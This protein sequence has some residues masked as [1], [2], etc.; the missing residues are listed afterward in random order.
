MV[1][2]ESKKRP[3][4]EFT[5]EENEQIS[6]ASTGEGSALQSASKR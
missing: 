2:K 6:D 5:Q 3:A 4:L 1:I